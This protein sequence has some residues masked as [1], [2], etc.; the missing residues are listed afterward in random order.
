MDFSLCLVLLTADWRGG[1]RGDLAP[2]YSLIL[3]ICEK[4]HI[5]IRPYES[6]VFSSRSPVFCQCHWGG[7]EEWRKG[8]AFCNEMQI[9]KCKMKSEK[10]TNE[11]SGRSSF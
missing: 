1:G 6:R 8:V 4:G 2:T 7:V 9:E 3:S 11:S 10:L 5:S